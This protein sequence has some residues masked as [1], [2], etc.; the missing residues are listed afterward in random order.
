M[1]RVKN[2]R[3]LL[4][5]IADSRK[6]LAMGSEFGKRFIDPEP[7]IALPV[8]AFEQAASVFFNGEE[9]PHGHTDKDIAVFSVDAQIV[10]LGDLFFNGLFPFVSVALD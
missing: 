8:I 3:R 1:R 9:I 2:A 4:R 5:V 10:H 6:R 7:A